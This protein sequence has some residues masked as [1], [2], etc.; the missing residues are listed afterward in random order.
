MGW[1]EF[2]KIHQREVIWFINSENQ[3][4]NEGLFHRIG[5]VRYSR[6][7]KEGELHT[8]Q[9]SASPRIWSRVYTKIPRKKALWIF[10]IFH[11]FSV[12]I[13][14]GPW[15]IFKKKKK[16]NQIDLTVLKRCAYQ[17]TAFHTYIYNSNYYIWLVFH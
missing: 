10:P 4:T 5:S 15:R 2:F 1:N 17:R 9:I 8:R 11:F 16:C 14:F 7:R 12:K 3:I 6:Y 13:S